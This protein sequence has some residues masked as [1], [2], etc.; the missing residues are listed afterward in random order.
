MDR[1]LSRAVRKRSPLHRVRALIPITARA[2]PETRL[3]KKKKGTC[4]AKPNRTNLSMSPHHPSF[5]CAPR[6]PSRVASFTVF[7]R[8]H[9]LVAFARGLEGGSC[10]A[11]TAWRARQEK[12][13]RRRKVMLLCMARRVTNCSL[14]QRKLRS[15]ATFAGSRTHWRLCA[16]PKRTPA[17]A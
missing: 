3:G 8:V 12:L 2:T 9:A 13:W 17:S 4:R 7:C 11:W 14:T 6:Q 5:Q 1:P 15:P 10:A 16:S